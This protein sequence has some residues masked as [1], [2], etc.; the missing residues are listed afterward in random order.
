MYNI[1]DILDKVHCGDLQIVYGCG[2]VE[3]WKGL[4][5]I[6]FICGNTA[7]KTD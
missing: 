3:E 6:G 1:D 2:K 7:K 5:I 4:N